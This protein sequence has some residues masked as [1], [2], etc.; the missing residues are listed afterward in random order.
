MLEKNYFL[1]IVLYEY[2]MD[3]EFKK[4]RIIN[5]IFQ[6]NFIR[7]DFFFIDSTKNFIRK[8]YLLLYVIFQM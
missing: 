4:Y 7:R 6:D 8:L 1:L 3:E 2:K 5:K